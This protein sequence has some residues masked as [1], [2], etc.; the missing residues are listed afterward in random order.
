MPR[1]SKY[2]ALLIFPFS[3]FVKVHVLRLLGHEV[4]R[5]AHIG[6]SYL[7]VKNIILGKNSQ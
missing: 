4:H 7:N 1:N 3:S 5:S 2:F 6:F